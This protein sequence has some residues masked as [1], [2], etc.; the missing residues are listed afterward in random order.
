LTYKARAAAALAVNPR[1]VCVADANF[2][3][4]ASAAF[5]FAASAFFAASI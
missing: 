2:F 5:F 1:S 4:A 3:A